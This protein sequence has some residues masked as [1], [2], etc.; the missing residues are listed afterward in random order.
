VIAA[1]QPDPAD[2]ELARQ[3]QDRLTRARQR[4]DQATAA[5]DRP[6]GSVKL[7]LA[8][9][10]QSADAI[11]CALLAGAGLIGENRVQELAAKGPALADLP[12]QT[13][14]IGQL[15]S[16]KVN[17]ALSWATCL[18]TID[19]LRLAQRVR[20]RCVARPVPL[21]VMVQVNTSGEAAKNGVD[22]AQAEDLAC[23][24]AELPG[25][26]LTG[27]MTVG[28]LTD[29]AAQIARAYADLRQIRDRVVAAGGSLADATELSM[30][31]SGDLEIA[32]AEGASIVRLGTA[33]FG[34][35]Q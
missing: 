8:T 27:F 22:P 2:S 3:I 4:I 16:N 5:A 30:G 28:P 34:P 6:A 12:H 17:S 26:R 24:V 35:R 1:D 23:Q 33:V 10:N 25:L 9:K 15:Q 29:D 11:R 32:I 14:F 7:L 21:E 31:M 19:S 18:E 20:L 13:H